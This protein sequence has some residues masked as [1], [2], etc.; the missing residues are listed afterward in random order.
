MASVPEPAAHDERITDNPDYRDGYATG[1][2]DCATETVRMAAESARPSHSLEESRDRLAVSCL[3]GLITVG[4][5]DQDGADA[6]LSLWRRRDRLTPVELDT[7]RAA[8]RDDGGFAEEFLKRQ[9]QARLTA[10]SGDL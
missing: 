9:Q 10:E 1:Y 6:L 8:S 4:M 5:I 2:V 3:S 7:L